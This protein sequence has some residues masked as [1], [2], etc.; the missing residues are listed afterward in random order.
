M[1]QVSRAWNNGKEVP[2][3]DLTSSTAP[4]QQIHKFDHTRTANP[5]DWLPCRHAALP[6]VGC[7]HSL[8]YLHLPVVEGLIFCISATPHLGTSFPLFH[9]LSIRFSFSLSNECFRYNCI[10]MYDNV[11]ITAASLQCSNHQRQCRLAPELARGG[12]VSCR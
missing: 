7:P 3:L 4:G 1:D 8:V 5:C 9:G 12:L 10:R 11:G 2:R 6:L